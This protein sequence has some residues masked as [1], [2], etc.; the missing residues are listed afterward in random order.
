M[1]AK[2][3]M[4]SSELRLGGR[5]KTA[6]AIFTGVAFSPDGHYLASS[7]RDKSGVGELVQHVLGSKMAGGRSETVRLWR[8]SDGTVLQK[9]SEHDEDA[10]DVRFSPA[11]KW[12]ASASVDNSA[13][14]WP[15][16]REP[17]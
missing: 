4:C 16:H 10:H 8:V 14:L 1:L 6:R 17:R 2:L 15:L 7:S 13:I 11:G 3:K 5:L 12:L 9:L